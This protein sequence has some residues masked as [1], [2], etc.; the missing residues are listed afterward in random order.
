MAG[1]AGVAVFVSRG[2]NPGGDWQDYQG[3][4]LIPAIGLFAQV[5]HYVSASYP[6]ASIALLTA[7]F[8]VLAAY[9]AGVNRYV[10]QHRGELPTWIPEFSAA[11]VLM[12][13]VLRILRHTDLVEKEPSLVAYKQR[14]EARPAFQKA[15]AGQMEAFQ[16]AAA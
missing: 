6:T 14:C 2:R 7:Q 13:T 15:L 9:A 16:A 8:A 4:F 11:D 3:W 1:G 10:E 12:V 5:P